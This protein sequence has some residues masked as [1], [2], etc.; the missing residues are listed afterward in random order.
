MHHVNYQA[1]ACAEVD[2]LAES[3]EVPQ[4]GHQSYMIVLETFRSLKLRG[5][6][7]MGTTRK[8]STGP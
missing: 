3:C 7:K 4:V 8:R 6:T 1:V 2:A 5:L